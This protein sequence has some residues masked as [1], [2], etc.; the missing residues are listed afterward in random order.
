MAPDETCKNFFIFRYG[1]GYPGQEK[2][3]DREAS[4][5]NLFYS[6]S[7]SFSLA[8]PFRLR[9][10][11]VHL[12]FV[13]APGSPSAKLSMIVVIL[14]NRGDTRFMGTPF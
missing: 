3:K 11:M 1:P 8:T 12:L 5:K 10:Y 4:K 2:S 14:L 9:T 7:V 6:F 13:Q